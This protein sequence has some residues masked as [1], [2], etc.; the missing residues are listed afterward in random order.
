MEG[1]TCLI[2]LTK[3]KTPKNGYWCRQSGEKVLWRLDGLAIYL[4]LT[5]SQPVL[6]PL[7]CQISL[8]ADS[9]SDMVSFAAASSLISGGQAERKPGQFQTVG[10]DPSNL[11]STGVLSCYF[12][13]VVFLFIGNPSY[14]MYG[15]IGLYC[16]WLWL[17][18]FI[19]SQTN[20][21]LDSEKEGESSVAK[22]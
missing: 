6:Q 8:A 3:P 19:D 21:G 9:K 18:W 10:G 17:I 13:V 7:I 11:H 4:V 5:L 14:L 2:K 15:R 22:G 12:L 1:L 20:K 16:S